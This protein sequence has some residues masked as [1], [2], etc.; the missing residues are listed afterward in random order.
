MGSKWESICPY[1]GAKYS[2]FR[3][4]LTY[5]DIYE[6]LWSNSPD[7]RHWRYKRRHTILGKW[8]QLKQEMWEEHIY[9]CK[10]M[11][12]EQIFHDKDK[13]N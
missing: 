9:C 6:M 10:A 3:T 13:K 4:G 11:A 1:C 2:K 12:E 8:C 5:K 7:P